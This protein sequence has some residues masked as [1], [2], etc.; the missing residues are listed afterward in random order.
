MK[1]ILTSSYRLA[2]RFNYKWKPD[3]M[4]SI[5]DMLS[6]IN[7]EFKD[8]TGPTEQNELDDPEFRNQQ[9]IAGVE[10]W[11]PYVPKEFKTPEQDLS[12]EFK[13]QVREFV[14]DTY[15]VD[16]FP[17]QNDMTPEWSPDDLQN[18]FVDKPYEKL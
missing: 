16:C 13:I 9:I 3:L 17:G 14:Y 12:P 15:G 11:I 18:Q 1:I 7:P 10:Q 2:A 5:R 4:A 6:A 8:S